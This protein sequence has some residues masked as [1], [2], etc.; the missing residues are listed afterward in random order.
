[1]KLA[2]STLLKKIEHQ[3]NRCFYCGQCLDDVIYEIDHIK[4]FL[5][6]KDGTVKNLCLC[7]R[8]CNSIKRDK[9]LYEFKQA[10]MVRCPH[11]LISG[12]FYFEILN[13]LAIVLI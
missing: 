9:E 2:P 7:C 3:H 11:F 1:M 13:L 8:T 6:Y 12:K 10:L 5:I 4:P